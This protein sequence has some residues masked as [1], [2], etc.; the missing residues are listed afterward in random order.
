MIKKS[1]SVPGLQPKQN[2]KQKHRVH[3]ELLIDDFLLQLMCLTCSRHL[4][5]HQHSKAGM[6]QAGSSPTHCFHWLSFEGQPLQ[7]SEQQHS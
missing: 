1:P 6:L 3:Q 7:S 4:A 2:S 5:A